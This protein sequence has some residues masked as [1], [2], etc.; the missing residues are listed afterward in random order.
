MEFGIVLPLHDMLQK[1]LFF[2][3]EKCN[4]FLYVN[5]PYFSSKNYIFQSSCTS[6]YLYWM[7]EN[8]Q[9]GTNI[10][11]NFVKLSRN[12]WSWIYIYEHVC[13]TYHIHGEFV[14]SLFNID[15]SQIRR[16]FLII[17]IWTKPIIINSTQASILA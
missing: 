16:N 1:K 3:L 13:K 4:N 15:I 8:I 7:G 2:F 14:P 9:R 6:F 5:M 10:Y 12:V 11:N 17:C